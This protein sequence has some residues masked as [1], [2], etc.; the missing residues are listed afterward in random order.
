MRRIART[1]DNQTLLV[2]VARQCGAT[3]QIL[4]QVGSGCPD[5]LIGMRGKNFLVE[6]KDGTQPPSQRK[7]TPDQEKWHREWNGQKR[8]ITSVSEMI[9]FL[10]KIKPEK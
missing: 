9:E 2:K 3:V 10:Q 8:V 7:L 1:D 4:S 6:V 5:L